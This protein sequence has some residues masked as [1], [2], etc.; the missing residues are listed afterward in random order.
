MAND[1]NRS[2]ANEG[3]TPDHADSDRRDFLKVT[4]LGAA[5]VAAGLAGCTGPSD[6][7]DGDGG[8][9][10][11][12][13]GG[14]GGLPDTIRVGALGPAEQSFGSSIINSVELAADEINN[15]GGIG[16]NGATVEVVSGDTKDQ[17]SVARQRYEEMTSGGDAVDA[18][19][20]IFGSEQLLALMQNIAQKKT[21]H[22][23]AGSATPEAP[24]QVKTDYDKYKYWFRVGR[25]TP[26]SWATACSSTLRT[27]SPIWAGSGSPSSPSSTSGRNRSPGRS[28]TTSRTGRT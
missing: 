6:G 10:D 1:G 7:G 21:V 27:G 5:G 18:T 8:G 14:S 9:G 4:G 25:S 11:G 23:T 17:P 20:G 16:E 28:R 3:E 2:G 12:G 13:D 15:D 24:A 26:R 22:L 19:I